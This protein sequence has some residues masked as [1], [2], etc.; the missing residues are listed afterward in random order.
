MLPLSLPF[1][2]QFLFA[3]WQHTESSYSQAPSTPPDQ[4]AYLNSDNLQM[5]DEPLESVQKRKQCAGSV[6][7]D[8]LQRQMV[9]L[10]EQMNPEEAARQLFGVGIISINDLENATNRCDYITCVDL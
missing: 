7:A 8:A 3:I 9:V 6:I 2:P 1:P 4:Q 10:M 5:L